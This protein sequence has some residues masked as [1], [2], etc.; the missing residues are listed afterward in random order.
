MSSYIRPAGRCAIERGEPS[1][2]SSCMRHQHL[3][4]LAAMESGARVETETSYPM[5]AVDICC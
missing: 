3:A 4:R 1:R 5:T 2:W